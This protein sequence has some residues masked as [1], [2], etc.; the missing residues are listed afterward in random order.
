MEGNSPRV[1]QSVANWSAILS[2]ELVL[3]EYAGDRLACRSRLYTWLSY[4]LN[5][6]FTTSWDFMCLAAADLERISDRWL[7][8]ASVK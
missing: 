4:G 2:S 7:G 1:E 3:S 8:I 6:M 5:E